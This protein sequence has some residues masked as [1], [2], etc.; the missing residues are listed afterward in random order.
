MGNS[1]IIYPY[2][3]R[4]NDS[5]PPYFS[6][7]TTSV[8]LAKKRGIILGFLL[9]PLF[10]FVIFRIFPIFSSSTWQPDWFNSA[11]ML[12]QYYFS[13]LVGL[14]ALLI[15]L[16]LWQGLGINRNARSIFLT[17]G[18]IWLAVLQL[19][20]SLAI[21]YLIQTQML[22]PAFIWALFLSLPS[23]S[24]FFALA[25]FRWTA[26]AEK[27]I[28]SNRWALLICNGIIF[29]VL[30]FITFSYATPLQEAPP[31]LAK[32]LFIVATISL[33][34]LIW[35]AWRTEEINKKEN[36]TIER[37][38]VYTIILLAQAEIYLSFGLPGTLSW[39]LH[40]PILL[41]A[42]GVTLIP[43]L[44]LA[45][46][47]QKE[48]RHRSEL[49]QLIVHDLKSPL[50]IVISGL[51]LLHRG[52]LGEVSATQEN[53]IASLEH[54]SNEVLRLVDDMLDVERLE[55][56]VMPLFK[57]PRDILPLL[58]EQTAELQIL[59]KKHDQNLTLSAPSEL[60]LV[61][62]DQDLIR[63]VIHNLISNALK[64]TP[65]NGRIAIEVLSAGSSISI[66]VADNGPGIP[67]R[68]RQRV[69]EKFAQLDSAHR[70]GKGL[71]LT[72]CKMVIEA[73]EGSL[74]VE[75]SPFG[76]ALFKIQLPIAT[77][78]S[79]SEQKPNQAL[80]IL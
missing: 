73:H 23:S 27:W 7:M 63:R 61:N 45:I 59:A 55:E 12:T 46:R 22:H 40:Q 74:T 66:S 36:S 6:T 4:E 52:H 50:T 10:L 16:L 79:S 69:F 47:Y 33:T 11:I 5:T 37:H 75:D 57:R 53:L 68:E 38:L 25:G 13:T 35:A 51:E 18:F 60:P 24:I 58:T 30:L 62:I 70:R 39:T 67:M 48:K 2:A 42:L 80:T 49:T 19:T 71:G 78:V 76:G 26:V 77:A 34:L 64:F 14:L 9:S 1:S 56:G 44:K 54:C 32:I 43:L 28:T 72:F 15:A 31:Y 17:V 8:T 20:S 41:A 65:N 3:V 21:P 29:A